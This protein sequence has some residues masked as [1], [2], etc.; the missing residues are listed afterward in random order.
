MTIPQ[1]APEWARLQALEA[2]SVIHTAH[3]AALEEPARIAALV[4]QAPRT[5]VALVDDCRVHLAARVGIE[6]PSL[7]RRGRSCSRTL[8]SETVAVL[9]AAA[10]LEAARLDCPLLW[11]H[12]HARFYASAPVRLPQGPV[13]GALVVL[14][15]QP[16]ALAH[17]HRQVLESLGRQLGAI[18]D[19]QSRLR[20]S[21]A[22]HI[23]DE[24]RRL[25]TLDAQRR[26]T[27]KLAATGRMAA[28]LAHE[29]NNPLGG[30]KNAFLLLKDAIP[31]THRYYAYVPRIQKEIDRIARIVRQMYDLY[32]PEL[33][34][35]RAFPADQALHDI[36]AFLEPYSRQKRVG[37]DL[38][39]DPQC[40]A[41]TLPE[42]PF[43]QVM[44][45]LL[46]NAIDA[47]PEGGR[48]RLDAQA[49]AN[50]AIFSVSDRGAGIPEGIRSRV[51]E[52]FFSTKSGE[53]GTGLGL[54]LSV[55]RGLAEG[56]GG[57]LGFECGSDGGTT[58]R[59]VVP[60]RAP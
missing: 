6:S 53:G 16:R 60:M 8:L 5:A 51:F 43:R 59:L 33:D 29:I 18:L 25:G 32:R 27:E 28:R 35:A 50:Q 54:G 52:P 56:M 22:Q 13:L 31:N 44:Y 23:Q 48:V 7:A 24:A 41:V 57:T 49:T 55:C 4:C 42:G 21:N 15:D 1:I 14:D 26:E 2:C 46:Q 3:A 34:M 39:I 12:P 37:F 45:N 36:V 40:R 58:F 19:L 9:D 30:I 10:P 17:D 20:A 38:V 11:A 47:S